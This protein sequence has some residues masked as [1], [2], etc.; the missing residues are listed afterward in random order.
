MDPYIDVNSL[1]CSSKLKELKL[2]NYQLACD[3]YNNNSIR[4]HSLPSKIVVQTTDICNL[5]CKMCQLSKKAKKRSME[6]NLFDKIVSELFPTLIELHPTN[7]GEALISPWFD[8]L[9]EKMEQYG[10]LLDLTTNGM[11]LSKK[12]IKL[13]MPILRDIKISFDGS[14]KETFESIRTNASFTTICNN[15][16]TLVHEIQ[17]QKYHKQPNVSLQVTIMKQNYKQLPEIIEVAHNLGVKSVKAYHLFS[18]SKE[19]DKC[20]LINE[21]DKWHPILAQALRLGDKYNIHLEL[22]EPL[23]TTQ[24]HIDDLKVRKCHLPWHESWIDYNGKIYACHSHQGVSVG[25]ITEQTFEDVW[26]SKLYEKVRKNLNTNKDASSLCHNCG[27][28]F[29]KD[30]EHQAVPYDHE[31]FL[32]THNNSISG[33]RW[34]QRMRPFDIKGIR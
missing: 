31:S 15:I 20:S 29:M 7:I 3:E 30:Y 11:L 2:A 26:N 4:L 9:C 16:R 6:V 18:F 23:A 25:D 28:N 12:K 14:R 10:V 34:S 33:I 27:M 13:I 8:Y 19:M 5:A 1:R 21:F 22:A 24:K 32:S 17:S